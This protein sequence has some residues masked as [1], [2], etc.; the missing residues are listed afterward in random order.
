MP[1]KHII[2]FFWPYEIC[3]NVEINFVSDILTEDVTTVTSGTMETVSVSHKR[4]LII[5]NDFTVLHA[6]RR[7][8]VLR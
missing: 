6:G 3:L 5:S 8:L 1:E 4:N 7:T 2:N